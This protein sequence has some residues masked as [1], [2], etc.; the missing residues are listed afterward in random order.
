MINQ[1]Y[2]SLSQAP[3]QIFTKH[4]EFRNTKTKTYLKLNPF[5]YSPTPRKIKKYEN[6]DF[7]LIFIMNFDIFLNLRVRFIHLELRDWI[8][9]IHLE[10]YIWFSKSIWLNH[11]L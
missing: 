11:F 2:T 3:S 6:E 8:L 7:S 9:F 5:S 1:F 10:F 4:L